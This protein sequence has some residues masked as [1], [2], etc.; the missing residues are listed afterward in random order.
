MALPDYANGPQLPSD[1]R[2]LGDR[3]RRAT[4]A[5]VDLSNRVFA[6]VIA[7][8]IVSIAAIVLALR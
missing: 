7:I 6:I 2:Q 5:E 1:T 4:S 3:E 8:I